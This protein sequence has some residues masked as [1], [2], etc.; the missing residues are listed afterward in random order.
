MRYDLRINAEILKSYIVNL[1]KIMAGHSKWA[2]IK[3]KKAV[4]DAKKGKEF[5][6]LVRIISLAARGLGPNPDMN[7]QLRNA[8]E[9]AQALN[10][11]K[12]NIERA[13]KKGA[14]GEEGN[15][16]PVLYEAYGPGGVALIIEGITDNNNRTFA[17]IRKIL[18]D[19]NAKLT[20]GGAMW[21][22]EKTSDGWQAKTTVT[23]SDESH[24][25]ALEE[26]IE[27][28]LDHDD[29]QEVYVNA[30]D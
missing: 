23:L 30:E 6:K 3:H 1:L 24:Q 26:L 17:E 16:Q 25:R 27:A 4:T 7:P 20:P 15:L 19:K 14:G 29:I 2:Q 13:I 9:K 22:F 10:M 5:S 12:E 28:L 21:M 8:I 18:S 11:P